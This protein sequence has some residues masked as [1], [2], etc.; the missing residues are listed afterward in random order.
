MTNLSIWIV[1]LPIEAS[2][3]ATVRRLP[4]PRDNPRANGLC[5]CIACTSSPLA[6][7]GLNDP[8]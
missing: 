3:A 4:S 5:E 8:V 1:R 7:R 2:E 6:F